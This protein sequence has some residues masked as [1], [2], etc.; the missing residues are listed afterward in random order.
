M[1][2]TVALPAGLAQYFIL[3][4]TPC[5]LVCLSCGR[6]IWLHECEA[7]L[8]GSKHR[9]RLPVVQGLISMLGSVPEL[10]D[11]CTELDIPTSVDLP[12]P[13]LLLHRDGYICQVYPARCRYVCRKEKGMRDHLRTHHRLT[14]VRG[15]NDL[16]ARPFHENW[17]TTS[18]QQFFPNRSHSK[19]F[20]VRNPDGRASTLPT[21]APNPT[22]S[23]LTWATSIAAAQMNYQQALAR[24]SRQIVAGSVDEP[25]AWLERTE[26]TSYLS[27]FDRSLLVD[28]ISPPCENDDAVLATIYHTVA[29]ALGYC[30]QTLIKQVGYFIRLEARR[31]EADE[32]LTKPLRPYQNNANLVKACRP[33]QQIF[34]FFARTTH[35]PELAHPHYQ[36]TDA[37]QTIWRQ[38]WSFATDNPSSPTSQT[39]NSTLDETDVTI[40][41]GLS[42]LVLQLILS[43]LDQQVPGRWQES[44]LLCALALLGTN[45]I[46]W[47]KI[48]QYTSILSA[49]LKTSRMVL[50]QISF[51]ASLRSSQDR[52]ASQNIE[53][54]ELA[55]MDGAQSGIADP[56]RG[57]ALSKCLK[58]LQNHVQRLAIRGTTG[59]IE[60]ILDLR[61]YGMKIAF[62]TPSEGLVSW[63]QDQLTYL[64][65]R[66]N[67]RA[68]KGFVHGLVNQA[69]E[70][71]FE[72]L[73]FDRAAINKVP[74][75]PWSNLV[76]NPTRRGVNQWFGD[77]PCNRCM[78]D[79]SSWLSNR[80]GESKELESRFFIGLDPE[81]PFNIDGIHAYQKSMD[82]FQQ[83]LL[84]LFHLTG[85]QPAR[86]PEL[87]SL[88]YRNTSYGDTR[89]IL[90]DN[91]LMAFVTLYHKG[92]SSSGK[93]K[94]IHRYIPREVGTLLFYYLAVVLPFFEPL[95]LRIQNSKPCSSRMW[96]SYARDQ[97]VTPDRMRG[98]LQDTTLGM[99]GQ[100]INIKA[101]RHII[102]AITRRY[103]N[104]FKGYS[105][106]DEEADSSS[107][108]DILHNTLNRQAAHSAYIGDMVYARNLQEAMNSTEHQRDRFRLVSQMWHRFL[109]F[110]SF[111]H[112]VSGLKRERDSFTDEMDNLHLTRWNTLRA[113]NLQFSLEGMLGEGARFRDI[114]MAA[115]EAIISGVSPILIVMATG[116]GKSLT[117]LL[118]S[119]A[120][121]DGIT[122]VV[123]PLKAIQQDLY[124]R[125]TRLGISTLVWDPSG[126]NED[127]KIILVTPESFILPPFRMFL[128]RIQDMQLLDRLVVDEC[129]EF[130]LP[131][132][133]YRNALTQLYRLA[134]TGV[135]MVFMSAT[136]PH[137]YE[138]LLCTEIHIKHDELR[139]FRSATNRANI[140]YQVGVIP[141]ELKTVQKR[142]VRYVKHLLE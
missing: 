116:A 4:L 124:T 31:S 126:A 53:H 9:L 88:R 70:L 136:M 1:T 46:S 7:H 38:L 87:L 45:T 25:N 19:Y 48:G 109:Q 49:I 101:C 141:G 11:P 15:K 17:S 130:L 92:Y 41:T 44:P 66:F 104:S 81:M 3:L 39:F 112:G 10:A 118:P 14:A 79:F 32:K 37:Q 33:W 8:R 61:A 63:N 50:V 132:R 111:D 58:H 65:I 56:Y 83:K 114:Q 78:S 107:D 54:M 89:N 74:A 77:D 120:V 139:V 36:F 103:L 133:N 90:I 55:V 18:C 102:I 119:W 76:D 75:I 105:A 60:W 138:H 85:G 131:S 57:S 93:V 86:A 12:I 84:L 113:L 127:S 98:W 95:Y 64:D 29:I 52:L 121:N 22:A 99:L 23:G 30:H 26:W 91:G 42:A 21:T 115:I 6:A 59:P 125:C 129:H 2:D 62:N 128:Q 80:I 82:H 67:M 27:G 94:T 134:M 13:G 123:L 73:L 5:L 106:N 68:F 24:S 122:V 110:T 69:H 137:L 40:V 35:N 43:L 16:D 135:Q 108:E 47:L 72:D 100:S 20:E 71:L 28:L 96:F 97:L 117:F 140:R 142:V 34:M 51:E